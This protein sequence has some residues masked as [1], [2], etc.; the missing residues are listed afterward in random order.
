M[1]AKLTKREVDAAKPASKDVLVWD[2]ELK[3][4]GLK[5]TPAGAKIYL[6]Q[7]RMGGRG[8][9][10][11]RYV[12]SGVKCNGIKRNGFGRFFQVRRGWPGTVS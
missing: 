6:I 2:T 12:N 8:A 1:K 11:Q 3:G 7:Y 4:F 5:V 10:V 9:R